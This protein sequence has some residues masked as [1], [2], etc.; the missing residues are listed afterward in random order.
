M[1]IKI[2][3]MIVGLLLS[4]SLIGSDN[5]GIPAPYHLDEEQD[6]FFILGGST[7]SDPQPIEKSFFVSDDEDNDYQEMD[8]DIALAG[9]MN[10]ARARLALE[11][12]MENKS[13][14]IAKTTADVYQL[15]ED[16]G[17]NPSVLVK[18]L[19]D[20]FSEEYPEV[21]AWQ[22]LDERIKNKTRQADK[23]DWTKDQL[24]ELS[25]AQVVYA[26]LLQLSKEKSN[27]SAIELQGEMKRMLVEY[28]QFHPWI[29]ES[30]RNNALQLFKNNQNELQEA[31]QFVN[32]NEQLRKL[33]NTQELHQEIEV[34][35]VIDLN[36]SQR[37]YYSDMGLLGLISQDNQTVEVGDA[38]KIQKT[39]DSIL[40][41]THLN[42]IVA[43]Y[44]ASQKAKY[45]L[46]KDPLLKSEMIIQLSISMQD[47]SENKND[48]KIL[49]VIFNA[50]F[51]KEISETV[52]FLQNNN[53]TEQVKSMLSA[54]RWSYDARKKM[55]NSFYSIYRQIQE[56]NRG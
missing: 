32:Q 19:K 9:F 13:T 18:D 24:E 6:D 47:L 15:A 7:G 50:F 3:K 53:S 22:Y 12:S 4:M 16:A 1:N 31:F 21:I 29:Q 11:P 51:D 23:P 35:I 8:L 43:P 33:F 37:Q 30:L 34:P 17:I 44:I 41:D 28:P 42:E 46:I 45:N 27:M 26:A 38:F 10:S 54:D 55:H 2:N 14:I 52:Q 56:S 40:P 5:K 36:Q 20:L 49:K 48:M 39:L 25:K